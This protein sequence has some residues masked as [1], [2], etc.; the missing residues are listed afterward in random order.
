M[1]APTCSRVAFQLFTTVL[2]VSTIAN[3]VALPHQVLDPR[4]PIAQGDQLPAEVSA[5]LRVGVGEDPNNVFQDVEDAFKSRTGLEVIRDFFARIFGWDEPSNASST[6]PAV[7]ATPTPSETTFTPP[8]PPATTEV[9]VTSRTTPEAS[10][11]ESPSGGFSILPVGS[12]ST[13]INVTFP[14]PVFS[15]PPFLNSSMGPLPTAV[16]ITGEFSAIPFPGAGTGMPSNSTATMSLQLTSVILVTATITPS[17][18]GTGTGLSNVTAAFTDIPL[19]PNTTSIYV[20]VP[21]GTGVLGT[22]TGS[23][24]AFTELPLYPNA[25]S[26]LPVFLPVSGTA[27]GTIAPVSFTEIPFYTNTTTVTTTVTPSGTGLIGTGAVG[28]VTGTGS[29]IMFTEIPIFPN[30]TTLF[31]TTTTTL[32]GTGLP[33]LL[34]S[35]NGT[36]LNDTPSAFPG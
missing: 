21:T 28:T 4:T 14:D 13:A 16:P 11:T 35:S 29:P 5:A 33:S 30:V 10:I 12:M 15:L 25:T 20:V 8:G 36:A 23:P 19:F 24:V 6:E 27:A 17:A 1:M 9:G 34:P 7:S 18:V 31:S 3:A 22:G 26:G 2:L 32:V